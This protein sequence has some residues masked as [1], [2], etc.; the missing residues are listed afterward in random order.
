M[1]WSDGLAELIQH[2]ELRQQMGERAYQDVLD[3]YHP[4]VRSQELVNTLNQIHVHASGRPLWTRPPSHGLPIPVHKND[5][6]GDPIWLSETVEQDPTL[7]RMA[8][9]SLRHRGAHTLLKQLWIYFRRLISP[10]FPFRKV[11]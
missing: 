5:P 9:Y 8:W 3:R 11:S 10:I 6:F 7:A 4:R 1:D 2:S